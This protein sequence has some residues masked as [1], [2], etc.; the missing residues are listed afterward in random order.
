MST[1]IETIEAAARQ[2]HTKA[3][4][5]IERLRERIPQLEQLMSD[6]T[7]EQA[8]IEQHR[9]DDSHTLAHA[10]QIDQEASQRHREAVSYAEYAMGMSGE[11]EAT[12]QALTLE[13]RAKDTHKSYE[14]TATHIEQKEALR[15]SRLEALRLEYAQAS[16]EHNTA[17]ARIAEVQRIE[18]TALERLGEATYERLSSEYEHTHASALETAR[19]LLAQARIEEQRFIDRAEQELAIWPDL[20][21]KIKPD[22]VY[23]DKV[24]DTC[25]IF[26]DLISSL[27]G[28]DQG[29]HMQALQVLPSSRRQYFNW[30]N[31]FHLSEPDLYPLN[32]NS[33][34]RPT[35]KPTSLLNLQRTMQAVLDEYRQ[36]KR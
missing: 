24:T 18:Q 16:D 12:R 14:Q 29:N 30:R 7:A 32:V 2:I 3:S 11:R 22:R 34:H 17:V 9:F 36:T 23:H 1:Q 10:R 6:L 21:Q 5:E 4:S 35:H 8:Q 33:Y 28:D 26:I 19:E 15:A 13:E 20:A 27:I 31:L 25:Q